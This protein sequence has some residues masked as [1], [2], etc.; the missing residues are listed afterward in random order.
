MGVTRRLQFIE[1]SLMD[2]NLQELIYF[3]VLFLC[4]ALIVGNPQQLTGRVPQNFDNS[5]K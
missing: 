4:S 3:Y 2:E 1:G 5:E